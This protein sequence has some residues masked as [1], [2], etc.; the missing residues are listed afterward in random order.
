LC[1]YVLYDSYTET[2]LENWD[3]D[4]VKFDY[5]GLLPGLSAEHKQEILSIF[6]IQPQDFEGKWDIFLPNNK[7]FRFNKDLKDSPEKYHWVHQFFIDFYINN[8]HNLIV[9]SHPQEKKSDAVL[10]EVLPHAKIWAKDLLADIFI[11]I[12]GF[13]LENVYTI[14]SNSGYTLG[15]SASNAYKISSYHPKNWY[16][17]GFFN[18]L[19][20]LYFL[21]KFLEAHKKN[22]ENISCFGISA[23]HVRSFFMCAFK[24]LLGANVVDCD[25]KT[26]DSI[27]VDPDIAI[28]NVRNVVRK[29]V[30]KIVKASTPKTV[31]MLNIKNLDDF[32][33]INKVKLKFDT[34]LFFQISKTPT[35]NKN[36]LYDSLADEYIAI[37][38]NEPS[39]SNEPMDFDNK[40]LKNAGLSLSCSGFTP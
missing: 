33:V 12:D 9:K 15:N 25:M 39:F 27:V 10:Q 1:E 2:F 35:R 3:M 21:C 32:Q 19:I 36:V 5:V 40:E 16:K 29:K 24:S 38:S 6:K 26:P 4:I 14:S 11:L 18:D 8:E 23:E 30:S 17:I 7:E 13:V 34:S 28:V 22:P 31:V 20:P 37:F